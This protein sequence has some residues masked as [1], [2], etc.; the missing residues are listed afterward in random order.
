MIFRSTFGR[1]GLL[2]IWGGTG[3]TAGA[4]AQPNRWVPLG[5]EGGAVRSVVMA[6]NGRTLYAGT[7]G[8]SVFRS[9]NRGRSWAPSS[10]GLR[11]AVIDLHNPLRQPGT[12]YAV[13]SEG[14]FASFDASRTWTP[15]NAGIP[16][17]VGL[18]S[19]EVAPS[20]PANLYVIVRTRA[21][22]DF[23]VLDR[24]YRTQNSGAGWS[25]ANRG[26]PEGAGGDQVFDLA[27]DPSRP[28]TVFAATA[29]GLFKTTNGGGR[30]ARSGFAGSQVTA[31]AI[32]LG[33]ES[34]SAFSTMFR[35]SLGIAPR[36]FIASGTPRSR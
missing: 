26:L 7:P 3:L 19:L 23:P 29:L 32:D 11:G 6:A 27:V 10:E 12:V 35:R 34:P 28:Q 22:E 16:L 30:W 24:V 33:Y 36:A 31:V 13:T 1:M 20:A 18:V 21:G 2:L 17:N 8:G 15:R 5:P 4:A 9:M 25:L 14:I